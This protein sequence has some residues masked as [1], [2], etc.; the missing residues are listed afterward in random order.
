MITP[1]NKFDIEKKLNKLEKA[2][3]DDTQSYHKHCNDMIANECEKFS[4]FRMDLLYILDQEPLFNIAFGKIS[5]K[6]ILTQVKRM[7]K[8]K[9][10]L[11]KKMNKLKDILD[12]D[13]DSQLESQ[14]K[15]LIK[16]EDELQDVKDEH[17]KVLETAQNAVKEAKEHL[18][19]EVNTATNKLVEL[20]EIDEKL[21]Q[22]KQK[23]ADKALENEL[24]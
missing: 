5:D 15:E 22:K 10:R 1:E 4:K 9:N 17:S 8:G 19:T 20:D 24:K 12:I 18:T 16:K 13:E 6:E 23:I 11:E 7:V 2:Y 14:V 3:F 21:E